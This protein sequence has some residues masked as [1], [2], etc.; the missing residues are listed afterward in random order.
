MDL[1]RMWAAATSVFVLLAACGGSSPTVEEYAALVCSDSGEGGRPSHTFDQSLESVRP[2]RALERFH[3]YMVDHGRNR[4][5][6]DIRA[7]VPRGSTLENIL[8]DLPLGVAATLAE[9]CESNWLIVVSDGAVDALTLEWAGGPADATKWQYRYRTWVNSFPQSWSRWQ[10]VP[11]SNGATRRYRLAG[12]LHDTAYDA[13]VRWVAG[14]EHGPPSNAGEG[15][16]PLKGGLK[17]VSLTI[18]EGDGETRWVVLDAYLVIPKG[19]RLQEG[20]AWV[21]GGVCTFGTSLREVTSG[22]VLSVCLYPTCELGRSIYH[23]SA[24]NHDVGAFF[25]RLTPSCP[26]WVAWENSSDRAADLGLAAAGMA[27]MVAYATAVWL[28]LRSR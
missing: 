8:L 20:R 21:N 23:G 9:A 13:Q 4:A 2:P 14:R 16:T 27:A 28:L 24:D 22:S 5:L 10:D 25:D 6:A 19:M 11:N 1:R 7:P 3:R 17:E 15:V 26:D 18:V 12:L